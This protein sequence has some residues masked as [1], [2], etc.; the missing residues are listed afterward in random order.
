MEKNLAKN[1]KSFK[2]APAS[3]DTSIY[4]TDRLLDKVLRQIPLIIFS[5][6][7]IGPLTLVFFASFKDLRQL[8]LDPLGLPEKWGFVNYVTLFANENMLLYFKNSV[9]VTFTSVFFIL[10]FG[11][12]ISYAIIRL[13]RW[14]GGLIFGFL[15]V[16]M[17][18]PAQVNMIPIYVLFAKLNLLNK[19][20][21]LIIVTISA[22]LPICVFILTGFMRA[23]PKG[24]IEAAMIDG[25]SHW[26]IYRRIVLPLS[27]PAMSSVAI[28]CFVIS[29]NDLL[30]PLLFIKSTGLKTIPLALLQFQGQ[31]L[32]NYP[33]IFA[34][35]VVASLPMIVIYVFLQRYFIAGMTAG[36]MKG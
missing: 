20:L 32:T 13:P 27:L 21:G 1:H 12:M 6:L 25:A 2:N 15:V 29:W 30:Y 18:I 5:L 35:V 36:S 24:L 34:G 33:M 7:I 3:E 8:Y 10:F 26:Q 23:L 9:F 22:L 28:F 14:L 11:S 31:Y 16:G 4:G 17:M 19:H